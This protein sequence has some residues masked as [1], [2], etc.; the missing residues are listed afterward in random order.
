MLQKQNYT[1]LRIYRVVLAGIGSI[2]VTTS[3]SAQVPTSPSGIGNPAIAESSFPIGS[4][5]VKVI[6]AESAIPFGVSIGPGN[7]ALLDMKGNDQEFARKFTFK[8]TSSGTYTINSIDFA[9]QDN[10]FELLSTESGE[11]FPMEIPPG[12]SFTIRIAFHGK[13]RNVLCSN[14]LNF[15]TEES[16]QPLTFA[17]QAMQLPLSS[18]PWNNKAAV[19]QAK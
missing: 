1:R 3:L 7:V 11:S 19:A 2:V 10:C 4:T 8:N 9:K 13:G 12:N 15:M 17:I 14:T 6:P 16:T 18:M 5:V